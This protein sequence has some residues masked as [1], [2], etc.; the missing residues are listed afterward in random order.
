MKE[1]CSEGRK[2]GRRGHRAACEV[3][4]IGEESRGKRMGGEE[5]TR[6]LGG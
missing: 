4:Q 1:R 2:G 6:L 3:Q 5:F